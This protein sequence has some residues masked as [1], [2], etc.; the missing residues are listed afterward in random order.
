MGSRHFRPVPLS[1]CGSSFSTVDVLVD[2][3]G[4]CFYF[5]AWGRGTAIRAVP[6]G[7]RRIAVVGWEIIP[8]DEPNWT[9]AAF[10]AGRADDYECE[11]A[12]M[13]IVSRFQGF[14]E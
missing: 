8:T 7:Q 1:L 2:E 5:P 10:D 11:L 6:H 12:L 13:G 4:P 14:Y 3:K 9:V